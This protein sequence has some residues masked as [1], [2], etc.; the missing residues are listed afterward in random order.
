M[1]PS[2]L[3]QLKKT[4]KG[5]VATDEE[6]LKKH[7]FD[8]SIFQ[9]K[10]QVVIYPKNGKDICQLVRFVAKNKKKYKDL[11]L[12]PRAAG[13]DMSGGTLTPINFYRLHEIFQSQTYDQ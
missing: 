6:T 1:N 8:K 12:A 3:A 13:T 9:V 10:P 4:L 11:S 7:S 2:L 5:E